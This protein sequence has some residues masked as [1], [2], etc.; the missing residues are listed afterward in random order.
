MIKEIEIQNFQSHKSTKIELSSGL[1]I[2]CGSSDS[3]KS[4]IKRSIEWA[5]KNRPSGDSI[6]SWWGGKTSVNIVFDNGS[7]ERSK[8]KIEEYVVNET[9]KLHAFGLSVPD[10]V[11]KVVN[12]TGVNLQSQMDMP[13]LLSET[14][15]A[16]ASYFNDVAGLSKI[17]TAQSKVDSWIRTLKSDIVSKEKDIE[18]YQLT[19][20]KYSGLDKIEIE[21]EVLEDYYNQ[22]LGKKNKVE[23]LVKLLKEIQ[24]IQQEIEDSSPIIEFETEINS[25]LA[26]MTEART[27]KKDISKLDGDIFTIKEFN[28]RIQVSSAILN[29]E[30]AILNLLALQ[31]SYKEQNNAIASLNKALKDINEVSVSIEENEALFK[32]LSDK[33]KK[34]M[35]DHCILCGSKL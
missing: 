28:K 25:L 14:S 19:L 10:E 33:F 22:Y 26:K 15:G 34:E 1:N 18:K 29:H 30:S 13:F 35:G 12:M 9:T 7:V 17:D 16:V 5:I 32:R 8:D 4:A 20:E 31:K 11:T 3:G 23:S 27:L 6:R 21:L 2:L 24:S